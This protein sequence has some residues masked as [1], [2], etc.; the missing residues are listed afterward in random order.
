LVLPSSVVWVK[1]WSVV[2]VGISSHTMMRPHTS[3][4]QLD[5]A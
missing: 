4:E 5:P 1:S 2:I 3:R